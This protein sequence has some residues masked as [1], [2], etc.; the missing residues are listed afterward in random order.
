MNKNEFL[1]AC[2]L[3][4]GKKKFTISDSDYE[5][6]EIVYTFHPSISET[7]GKEQIALLYATFGMTVINDMLPHAIKVR[8]LENKILQAKAAYNTAMAEYNTAMAEYNE[9]KSK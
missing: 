4:T 9:L 8:E 1:Y 3:I 6:I 2:E 7:R 5:I